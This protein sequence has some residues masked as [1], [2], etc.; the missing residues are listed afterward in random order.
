MEKR[1]LFYPKTVEITT[2]QK[3]KIY[4]RDIEMTNQINRAE[5]TR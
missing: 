1:E 2:T 3:Q 4:S 5:V